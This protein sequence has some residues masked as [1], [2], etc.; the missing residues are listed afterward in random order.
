LAGLRFVLDNLTERTGAL[1]VF[2]F[3]NFFEPFCF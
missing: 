3:F 2:V 1:R